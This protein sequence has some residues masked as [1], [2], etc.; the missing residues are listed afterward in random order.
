[1]RLRGMKCFQ[2]FLDVM[3]VVR[4]SSESEDAALASAPA[5]KAPR[6][7]VTKEEPGD[8]DELNIAKRCVI[9]YKRP[10]RTIFTNCGHMLSCV[11]CS[12][13]MDKCPVCRISVD[14][15]VVRVFAG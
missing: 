6:R 13:K 9:C 3:E 10:I 7:V 15:N 12:L 11:Q 14:G 4:D 1:M 5:A 2:E 8:Q